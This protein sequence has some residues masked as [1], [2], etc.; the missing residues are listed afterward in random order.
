MKRFLLALALTLAAAAALPAQ[1]L[2]ADE[3]DRATAY[4][5]KTRAAVLAA[6]KDLSEAQWSFKPGPTRW[7]VAEVMEHIAAS[8]DFLMGLIRDKVMTAPARTEPADVK[9]IDDHV[10]RTIPDRTNKATAPEPLM[11]TRRFGSP[12]ESLKHFRESRAKTLAF[13]AGTKDLREH[14]IPSPLGKVLDAYQWVLFIGA[15]SERHTKQILEV[16]ADAGFP[17]Q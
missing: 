4:L 16:K 2:S 6:T 10:L 7:S 1:A 11:P 17:K 14:A 8:E 13:L 15:H 3:L 12:A 9:A 5:E